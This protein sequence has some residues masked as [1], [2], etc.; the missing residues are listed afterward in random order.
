VGN[1]GLWTASAIFLLAAV[2][3]AVAKPLTNDEIYT[4][5]VAMQPSFGAIWSA[6]AA[7]ADNH[8]P[9]D[10]WLRHAAMSM[11]GTSPFVLRLPS[12]AAIW[13]ALTCIYGVLARALD[14]RHAFGA[15]LLFLIVGGYEAALSTRGYSLLLAS[16]GVTLLAWPAVAAGEAG[17]RE[18]VMFVGGL[19][20]AFYSH[21]YGVLHGLAFLLASLTCASRRVSIVRQPYPLLAAAGA[22]SLPLLPLVEVAARF[23]DRFWTPVTVTSALGFYPSLLA[24]VIPCLVA[25]A[26]C[27]ALVPPT[28]D[29]AAG[30]PGVPRETVHALVW[31]SAMPAAM[32]AIALRTGAL[33]PRYAIAS[34]AA[35]VMLAAVLVWRLQGRRERLAVIV[36]VVPLIFVAVPVLRQATGLRTHQ[37]RVAF[38]S[39]LEAFQRST[40]Q[41]V[42][43]GDDGV[44]VEVS[45]SDTPQRLTNCY[46]LYDAFPDRPTNVDKA[47]RGLLQVWPIRAVSFDGMKARTPQFAFIGN[48]G[49]RVLERSLADGARI[50]PR[51]DSASGVT[52]WQVNF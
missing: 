26:L 21:Y 36:A 25:I 22:L 7:G 27:A 15:S 43:I 16:F 44:F 34:G 48:W 8:P 1:P 51:T 4:L 23:S 49:D 2:P 30:A 31:F 3:F 35:L 28:E 12:L 29:A 41:P 9:L 38:T 32:L 11:L 37:F 50:E 40:G 19:L 17:W 5:R 24:P 6:L 20:V 47:I 33:L 13:L 18:R 45:H 52:Y 46:F 42:I 39:A 14:R 10:Y